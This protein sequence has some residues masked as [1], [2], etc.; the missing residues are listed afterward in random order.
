MSQQWELVTQY[1]SHFN[2]WESTVK[3]DKGQLA[4]Y[5]SNIQ[6]CT[7]QMDELQQKKYRQ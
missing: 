6:L 1:Q 5:D 2:D 4:T 7:Q 3:A